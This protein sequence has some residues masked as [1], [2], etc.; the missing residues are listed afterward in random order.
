MKAP[1]ITPTKLS[2]LCAPNYCPRCYWKLLRA[3]FKKPFDFGTPFV[4]QELDRHQKNVARIG[5]MEGELPK[6]FGPFK[7]ATEV[8]PI[9]SVSC[10]HADTGL[11]LFG[12]PDLVF[13]FADRSVGILD[14]KTAKVKAEDHPL[15]H[16]YRTQ[17]NHYAYALQNSANPRTVSRVGLLYYEFAHLSDE[18]MA[19]SFNDS[20]VWARFKP[21]VVEMDLDPEGIVVPLLEKVR[22]LLDLS[23]CPKGRKGCNDCALLDLYFRLKKDEDIEDL[24]D[25]IVAMLDRDERN[26]YFARRRS[27]SISCSDGTQMPGDRLASVLSSMA[28]PLGVVANWDYQ[29]NQADSQ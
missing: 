15:F 28:D 6:F 5:I 22:D 2:A 13:A 8:L 20:E 11:T 3:S 1:R 12:Y 27:R 14:D 19:D 16:S 24:D 25:N 7:D 26:E 29:S 4:M 23:E 10:V 18:E 9:S 21:K 17:V